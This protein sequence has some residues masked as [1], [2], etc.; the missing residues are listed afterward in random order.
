MEIELKEVLTKK[1]LKSFI[2]LPFHLYSNN[3]YWVPPLIQDELKN[4]VRIKIPHLSFANL[5]IG[6][7]IEKI[8]W[9]GE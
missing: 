7:L 1:D 8:K 9:W 2:K 5:A 4:L 6:L 3:K